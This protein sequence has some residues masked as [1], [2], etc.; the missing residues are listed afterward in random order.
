MVYTRKIGNCYYRYKTIRHGKKVI[1]KYLGK[2][3][4]KEIEEKEDGTYTTTTKN[5]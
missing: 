3:T 2:A 5:S 1:S 4:K